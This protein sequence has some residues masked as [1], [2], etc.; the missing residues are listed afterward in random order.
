MNKMEIRF[1]K[2]IEN[3]IYNLKFPYKIRKKKEKK[4]RK[5]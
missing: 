5:N 1:L 2:G 4:F 3:S